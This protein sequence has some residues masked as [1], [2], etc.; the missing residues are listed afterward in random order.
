MFRFG[1]LLALEESRAGSVLIRVFMPLELVLELG[2]A[3]V[4]FAAG[5]AGKYF[6]G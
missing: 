3:L 6:G 5:F 4:S 2:L 1:P